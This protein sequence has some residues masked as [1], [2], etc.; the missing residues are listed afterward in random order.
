MNRYE[1]GLEKLR[2]VDGQAGVN[3]I[4]SLNTV[5][6]DLGR[7]IVEFAFG[8]IYS[9]PGLDLR[10]RQLVTL[11]TLTTQGCCAP[12]LEVHVHASLNVGLT[13]LEIME[14]ILHCTPYV[15][16]PKVIN[17]VQVANKIFQKEGLRV[18]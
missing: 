18:S 10:Q 1:Q 13:P 8:D 11:A 17:A 16:F 7:Y 5:S 9:R 14:A 3:V 2:E 6:P 4:E 15:G 12:Q